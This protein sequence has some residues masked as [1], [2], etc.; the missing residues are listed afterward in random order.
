M[1]TDRRTLI[2]GKYYQLKN[3]LRKKSL[4]VSTFRQRL[5]EELDP[6]LVEFEQI[7]FEKVESFV[8]TL[9]ILQQEILEL[10]EKMDEIDA[11]YHIED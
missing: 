10:K 5:S 9:K 1:S 11:I 7:D 2:E 3:E 6:I 4:S 8:T